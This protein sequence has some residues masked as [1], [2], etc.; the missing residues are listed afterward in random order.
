MLGWLWTL[1]LL[2]ASV[3]VLATGRR[4]GAGWPL[5]G[6]SLLA[7]PVALVELLL[8]LFGGGSLAPLPA[9][10]AA[11]LALTL[12]WTAARPADAGRDAGPPPPEEETPPA[13]G[14]AVRPPD[15]LL[16]RAVEQTLEAIAVTDLECRGRF[17]N[18][19][20]AEL[21]GHSP[22]AVRGHHLA[23]FFTP[24]QMAEEVRPVLDAVRRDGGRTVLLGHRRRDGSTFE[25]HTSASLLRDAHG[26]AAGFV[27]V[28]RPLAAEVEQP[29]AERP[30]GSVEAAAPAAV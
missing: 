21:H 20:W 8:A 22:A 27:L 12:A 2:A 29:A 15:G 4:R 28:A 5:A 17:V 7:A 30:A 23:L 9:W 18:R 25:C 24:E 14:P 10:A 16:L 26:E 3:M 1:P 19:A 6:A 11:L 13:G